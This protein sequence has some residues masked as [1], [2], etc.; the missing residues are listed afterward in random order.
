MKTLAATTCAA[1]L[2]LPFG[3]A[4]AQACDRFASIIVSYADLDL[5]D[6][7]GRETLDHRINATIR[8]VCRDARAGSDTRRSAQRGCCRATAR[9]DAYRQLTVLGRSAN[10]QST[11]RVRASRN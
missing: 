10:G 9:A 8:R 11:V 1:A 4:F 6:R 5:E 2:A 7:S 3:A